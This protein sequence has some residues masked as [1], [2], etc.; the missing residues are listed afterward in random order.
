MA[1]VGIASK[2]QKQI[3]SH[4]FNCGKEKKSVVYYCYYFLS[5]LEPV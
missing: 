3:L 5:N 1:K 4:G 2:P